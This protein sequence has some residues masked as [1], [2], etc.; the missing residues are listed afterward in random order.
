[1]F[2]SEPKALFKHE[3]F[4]KEIDLNSLNKYF[5]FEY[6]PTPRSIYKGLNKLE[7]GHFIEFKN[8]NIKKIKFW[9]CL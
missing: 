5:Q 1:M 9:H 3:K 4:K 7:P 8:N 2:A 6:I